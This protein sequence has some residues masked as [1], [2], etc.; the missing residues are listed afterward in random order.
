MV[1]ANNK[2][3][4]FVNVRHRMMPFFLKRG[5]IKMVAKQ[6]R[7]EILEKANRVFKLKE[8]GIKIIFPDVDKISDKLLSEKQ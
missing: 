6:T 8:H 4:L 7:N 2:L 3:N 5:S 1:G